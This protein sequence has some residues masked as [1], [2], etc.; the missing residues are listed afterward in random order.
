MGLDYSFQW[1]SLAPLHRIMALWA[2]PFSLCRALCFLQLPATP[3]NEQITTKNA[4]LLA[5]SVKGLT[6]LSLS[7]NMHHLE[8][9]EYQDKD[10]VKIKRLKGIV[11]RTK[12]SILSIIQTPAIITQ[13]IMSLRSCAP[14][15]IDRLCPSFVIR[16][17]V[18]LFLYLAIKQV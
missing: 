4:H 13:D 12:S 14:P 7:I 6:I 8:F 9:I 5:T 3:C 10:H 15:E 17:Y 1:L 2:H 16:L 11:S 18:Q